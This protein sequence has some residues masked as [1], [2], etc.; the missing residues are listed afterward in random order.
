MLNTCAGSVVYGSRDGASEGRL[1]AR[2]VKILIYT[3]GL[4]YPPN[5]GARIHDFHLIRELS[6]EAKVVV[7]SL[8]QFDCEVPEQLQRLC[9]AVVT[10]RP[11]PRSRRQKVLAMWGGWREGRPLAL[12]SPFFP[13]WAD[14]IGEIIEEHGIDIVQ[15]EHSQMAGYVD[16]VPLKS[17]ARK[18]LSFHNLGWLQSS[19]EI[20]LSPGSGHRALAAFNALTM[21]GWEPQFAER[22]DHCLAVSELDAAR[23]RKRNP[24]LRVS[25]IENGVD[26]E[27]LRVLPDAAAGND[28]L[29]V[30]LLSYPPNADAVLFFC[31]KILPMIRA[32]VPDARL[33]VVGNGAPPAVQRLARRADVVLAG[34]VE[35]IV[36]CYERTRMSVVPL[37]AGSG[38]RLKI[39]ESMAL[40]RPV[41]TTPIGAEG[42]EVRDGAELLIADNPGDF[43]ESV[44]RVLRD[45]PLYRQL[46]Q[47]ARALVENRYDW[48]IIGGKLLSLYHEMLA[49]HA[50]RTEVTPL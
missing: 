19:R 16:A 48:R 27:R 24:R 45:P 35:S 29:F 42:L 2:I 41:V 17:K 26:C 4:P 36:P 38:T 47:K 43:S 44:V 3:R 25:V 23:L 32:K 1:S 28:L 20:Y 18:V 21:R 30:G 31:K 22:F 46:A 11:T 9:E 49:Q 14:R 6:R 15:I 10:F 7:C 37:R 50:V 34:A 13:E 5:T 33:L 8:L 39:L 40:G 12:H